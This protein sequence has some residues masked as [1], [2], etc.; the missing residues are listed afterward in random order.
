MNDPL[1]EIA[2]RLGL[3]VLVGAAVG[4]N[5]DLHRKPA[6]VRTHALVGLGTA[7][8]VIVVMPPGTDGAHRYDA[9]SRVIQGVLTGIGFLGAG[10]ILRDPNRLHVSGLTTAAT[11][12]VTSLLGIACGMGMYAPVFIALALGA[13]V[14]LLGGRLERAFRPRVPKAR[15]DGPP[16]S[17]Q[18]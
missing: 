18:P 16:D 8:M 1:G 3:A 9:L 14:L 7:L 5:R 4:L 10:V 11:V 15:D 17:Q 13:L 2:I 6:G 12:W